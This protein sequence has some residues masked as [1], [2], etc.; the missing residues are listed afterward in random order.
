MHPLQ[1]IKLLSPTKA[2]LAL[3]TIKT[4]IPQ[5][6]DRGPDMIAGIYN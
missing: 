1:I 4:P 6:P 5:A 2:T 3:G